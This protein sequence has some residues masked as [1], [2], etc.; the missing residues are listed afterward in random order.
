MSNICGID[1]SYT[2][3][4]IWITDLNGD[5]LHIEPVKT[6]KDEF[7]DIIERAVHIAERVYQLVVEYNVSTVNIEG[8]SYGSGGDQTRNLGGLYFLIMYK[9]KSL[10]DVDINIYAP[11]S[12]KLKATGY[13]KSTKDDMF[14]YLPD[15]IKETISRYSPKKVREDLTDAYHLCLIGVNNDS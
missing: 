1:Q 6:T 15:D 5:T 8:L 12:L 3:T 10:D 9:L 7:P 2:C 13:G 11:T 14:D 4:G